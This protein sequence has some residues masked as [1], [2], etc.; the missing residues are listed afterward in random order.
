MII[1][2]HYTSFLS[3]AGPRHY[4]DINDA[5][6]AELAYLKRFRSCALRARRGKYRHAGRALGA[7]RRWQ[8]LIL[9]YAPGY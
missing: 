3:P 4:I 1:S 8:V 7:L 9:I 5:A 2:I 6:F